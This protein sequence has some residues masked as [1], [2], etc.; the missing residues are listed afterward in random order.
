[1]T[2]TVQLARFDQSARPCYDEERGQEYRPALADLALLIGPST[3]MTK[4]M[5]IMETPTIRILKPGDEAAL[6]GF[7]LPRVE[8]SMFLIGNMRAAAWPIEGQIYQGTYAAR[9]QDGKI[10]GVV[11]TAGTGI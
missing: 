10:V 6:E 4:G 5:R 11:L 8:S 3:F 1:L 7:L 2:G 9:L